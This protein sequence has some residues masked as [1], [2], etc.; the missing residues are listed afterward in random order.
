MDLSLKNEIRLATLAKETINLSEDVAWELRFYQRI[1]GN[2][3]C[4]RSWTL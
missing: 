1:E 3:D 4:L 2:W